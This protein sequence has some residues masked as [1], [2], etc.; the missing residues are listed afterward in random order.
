MKELLTEPKKLVQKYADLALE[1][2]DTY[3]EAINAVQHFSSRT[4]LGQELKKAIQDEITE[5]ALNSNISNAIFSELQNNH[6]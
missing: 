3:Q 1:K 4:F 2:Y 6:E 5:R